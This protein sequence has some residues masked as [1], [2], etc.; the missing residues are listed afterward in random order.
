ML[1]VN[2]AKWA[3]A[4]IVLLALA[5]VPAPLLP[6]HALARLVQ[7]A[8]GL[9]WQ[10]A[11]LVAAVG[12]QTVFYL[13]LGVLAAFVVGRATTTRGRWLQLLVVPAA[14]VTVSFAIRCVKAG[15]A[16]AK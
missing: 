12:L 15:H 7:S 8:L 11:Y 13:A 16:I 3:T 5:I 9:G 4:A 10:G 6:P 1:T 2:K 14:V